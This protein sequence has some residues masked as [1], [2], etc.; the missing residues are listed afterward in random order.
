MALGLEVES[1]LEVELK[2]GMELTMNCDK[3][4][5]LIAV[6]VMECYIKQH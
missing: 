5:L 2:L 1:V 4:D 3:I 6:N